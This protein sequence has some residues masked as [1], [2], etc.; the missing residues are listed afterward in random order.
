MS[1]LVGFRMK[2]KINNIHTDSEE[3]LD[4]V[5]KNVVYWRKQKGFSQLQLAVAMGYE[6]SSYIGRMELRKNG[7]HF[8][9]EQLFK[10]TK[11]NC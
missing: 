6:S 8:N 9:I 10:I 1:V 3:F 5:S 4:A 7:Q 2:E 11:I